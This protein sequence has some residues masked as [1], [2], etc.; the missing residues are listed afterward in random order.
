MNRTATILLLPFIFA[1]PVQAQTWAQQQENYNRMYNQETEAFQQLEEMERMQQEHERDMQE[2]QREMELQRME[3]ES[4]RAE[5][6]RMDWMR[7][8]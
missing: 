6:E 2:Q 4:D 1:T 3:L 7:G 5:R 8:R